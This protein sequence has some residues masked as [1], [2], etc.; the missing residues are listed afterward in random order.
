MRR[1]GAFLG[2]HGGD[3]KLALFVPSLE[4]AMASKYKGRSGPSRPSKT[5]TGAGGGYQRTLFTFMDL[6]SKA[7]QPRQQL[8]PIV[9]S[10]PCAKP[11]AISSTSRT[12]FNA[13]EKRTKAEI[14]ELTSDEDDPPL[15]RRKLAMDFS[16]PTRPYQVSITEKPSV[17]KQLASG[18]PRK[19]ISPNFAAITPYSGPKTYF[20]GLEVSDLQSQHLREEC[21]RSGGP[22]LLVSPPTFL[23]EG[24]H[25]MDSV[26]LDMELD[27]V[28]CSQTQDDLSF[29]FPPIAPSTR[30]S[31]LRAITPSP[32]R[33]SLALPISTPKPGRVSQQQVP[34][35]ATPSDLRQ[36]H[37]ELIGPIEAPHAP[38]FTPYSP[39]YLEERPQTIDPLL[40]P[41]SFPRCALPVVSMICILFPLQHH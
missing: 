35:S 7:I 6:E 20:Q 30:A 25:G 24:E 28:P 18:S 19:W 38:I 15:K 14:I 5:S 1:S 37:D 34:S 41:S 22:S 21:G 17:A 8:S 26:G 36:S 12:V 23:P 3:Q 16:S 10:P 40:P 39:N 4:R 11:D 29:A 9:S 33:T 27:V 32:Q 31:P 13:G 2:G